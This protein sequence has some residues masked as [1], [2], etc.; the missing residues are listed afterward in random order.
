MILT[1][2]SPADFTFEADD[3]VGESCAAL[4]TAF[5]AAASFVRK[6]VRQILS[7]VRSLLIW[8]CHW[9]DHA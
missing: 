1:S 5:L 2:V 7:V 9:C 3:G 8:C 4:L 6:H